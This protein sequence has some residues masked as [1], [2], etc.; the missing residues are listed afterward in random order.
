MKKIK[1]GETS[2]VT[3][4]S[5]FMMKRRNLLKLLGIGATG[6]A[7]ASAAKADLFS[8]FTGNDDVPSQALPRKKLEFIQP[9][10]YQ[11]DLILTP[12]NKVIG[13]NNFYEFGL[14]KS[15]PANYAHTM[16]TDEWLLTIEG[17]VNRP[18]KLN[19]DDIH[20]KFT[21]EER[22]YRMRCVEAWSMVIP[23]VGFPLFRLLA[24]AEPNSR[25]KYVA[26]ETRYAPNEMPGQE[27][28]F[29]GGGLAYPY[30]E[31]LRLDEAMNPLTFM[32]T[33]VY[34]KALPNQNGAPIRLVV[35]WKYGFK[36]I[37]SIVTIRLTE[38][39][40]PTTWNLSAPNE[41]GF[42]AN[43]NP[44]VD[45]P[46]WSQA[47]E[48]F[49]GAGGLGQVTRQPTLMF[50]GYGEDVAYLYQGLDLRRNF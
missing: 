31:G 30:V 3:P 12:E 28:R 15:D 2:D 5:V 34:G 29:I 32:A 45:H 1:K 44:K 21:L 17:E 36:G 19:L 18:I 14:N 37:K 38:S 16:K 46:R 33:G 39:I 9:E 20:N 27:S 48:R 4:E 49:I 35:P 50:N 41:Y 40:P 42:Y 24:L 23:W 47:T 43:V 11:S 10:Q 8:W 13:Y 22:I 26:F 25:A 7:I 6:A